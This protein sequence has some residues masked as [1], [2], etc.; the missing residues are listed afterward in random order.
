MNSK[1][2]YLKLLMIGDRDAGREDLRQLYVYN[3]CS[4]IYGLTDFLVTYVTIDGE[5]VKLQVGIFIINIVHVSKY[6]V[7]SITY[8]HLLFSNFEEELALFI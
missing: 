3:E 1:S 4:D 6:V 2:G 5:Q 8:Q 7:N